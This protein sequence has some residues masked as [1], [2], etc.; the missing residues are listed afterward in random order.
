MTLTKSSLCYIEKQLTSAYWTAN[1]LLCSFSE[2]SSLQFSYKICCWDGHV[3]STFS[4]LLTESPFSSVI[5]TL[6]RNWVKSIAVKPLYIEIEK[7]FYVLCHLCVVYIC[8]IGVFVYV[9]CVCACIPFLYFLLTDWCTN[10]WGESADHEGSPYSYPFMLYATPPFLYMA[11]Q[12]VWS[13]YPR[14]D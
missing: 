10:T 12:R 3:L 8:M 13:V 4:P 14:E 9:W 11:L 6:G 7:N 2:L 5:W 1:Q